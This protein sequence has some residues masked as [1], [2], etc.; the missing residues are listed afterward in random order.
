MRAVGVAARAA[1]SKAV[2]VDFVR[3]KLITI[4][5]LEP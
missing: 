4:R 1:T 3:D 5:I 2:S